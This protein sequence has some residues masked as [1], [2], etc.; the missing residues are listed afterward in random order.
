MYVDIL[1]FLAQRGSLKL[2]H[3]VY[4]ANVNH[5]VPRDYLGFLI[6]Q[7]PIVE[8]VIVKSNVVCENT[9]R[10]CFADERVDDRK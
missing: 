9:V 8:R 4:K 10:A 7:G 2:T 3:F 5:N 6:K 1:K